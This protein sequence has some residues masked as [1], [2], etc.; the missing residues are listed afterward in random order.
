[1]RVTAVAVVCLL[2]GALRAGA[3]PQRP[4]VDFDG[5][6]K[7]DLALYNEFTGAWDI[8]R[9][10]SNFSV[11]L[12][13]ISFG[14]KG[15]RP[16]AGD[17]DGD[18]RADRAWYF[19]W[20][21]EWQFLRSSDGLTVSVSWGGAQ[22]IPVPGDYDGDG[23]TDIAV[24]FPVTGYWYILRST[25]NYTTSFA[26]NWGGRGYH[27][28]PADFDGDG[29]TD[30]AVY[31][32]ASGWWYVL[33]STSSFTAAYWQSLGGPGYSPIP[34]DFDG[35]GRADLAV[36]HEPTG[37][38]HVKISGSGYTTGFVRSWGG[39]GY[40][41]AA[42]D[43]DGDGR[44][45]FALLRRNLT[46]T[47]NWNVLLSGSGYTTAISKQ[48][49]SF[50]QTVNH[51]HAVS[52]A[53]PIPVN[54]TDQTKAGDIDGD[55]R[56]DLVVYAESTGAWMTLTSSSGFAATVPFSMG[57]AGFTPVPGD[58]DGDGKTDYATFE[59]ATGQW[60]VATSSSSYLTSFTRTM[61]VTVD[62]GTYRWTFV[63]AAG[64][65]DGD[66]RTDMTVYGG[67][68]AV[69]WRTK[70][71]SSDFTVLTGRD[72]GSSGSFYY[73]AAPADYDGN[74]RT[75]IGVFYPPEGTGTNWYVW[76]GPGSDGNFPIHPAI[77]GG[78]GCLAL[79]ADYD[80]DGRADLGMFCPSTARWYILTSAS[81]LTA[82][83]LVN[84]GTS[85]STPLV[86]DYDGDGLADPAVYESST[87]QW[88]IALSSTNYATTMSRTLG[89]PGFVPL[90]AI[91][92][93]VGHRLPACTRPDNCSS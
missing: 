75:E 82:N 33:T 60:S 49:G 89:G 50:D 19:P 5:D 1:M 63:P 12:P 77:W 88:T 36:Y 24:Y 90:P 51:A 86:G 9:S 2:F 87:G 30:A 67:F 47:A 93:P 34:E 92:D 11:P 66:G 43:H 59:R 16:V 21:G 78:A 10:D 26:V 48:S 45:D 29:R 69:Q 70:T 42:G 44:A 41:A 6:G 57:G 15:Y 13:A 31:H 71:S 23:R 14:G 32:A 17:Y 54:G 40:E 64:D 46:G 79:P 7:S 61:P 38:W 73:P 3:D 58:Y 83:I 74:G 20:T 28:A 91:P 62:P 8:I 52:A 18:G 65:F 76:W 81:G 37:T 25:T 84:L 55:G 39:S 72:F 85:T 35:D 80:G 22:Y 4:P 56:T 27:A 68:Y 53:K